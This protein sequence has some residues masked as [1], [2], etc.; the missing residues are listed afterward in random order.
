[1]L[2]FNLKTGKVIGYEHLRLGH[3]CQD[4]ITSEQIQLH[5]GQHTIVVISDGSSVAEDNPHL[6]HT[7]VG[8]ALTSEFLLE[9]TKQYLTQ[10]IYPPLLPFF[11]FDD[12]LEYYHS[13]IA[14]K[15]DIATNKLVDYVKHHLLCTA[16]ILVVTPKHGL[17][18][19]YGDGLIV[20]DN[21]ILT[22]DYNDR[23]PYPAYHLIPR[24][25]KIK[26][27]DLP[28]GFEVIEFDPS[29]AKKIA[30][31]SDSFVTNQDLVPLFW[32]HRHPDQIQR[33]L[34]IWS[35]IDHKLLDD[36]SLAVLE[37]KE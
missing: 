37:R 24:H 17:V 8:A 15:K 5:N 12:L 31:G 4:A 14:H 30:I 7:E 21:Q 22:F 32:G 2:Q 20:I 29:D 19:R 3:N 28:K 35:K 27:S 10:D 33:N 18:M 16:L 1:M 26:A 11:L 13:L 34:N 36:A 6:V 25:L 9:K 23:P